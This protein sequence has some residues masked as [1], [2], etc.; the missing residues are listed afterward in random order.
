MDI[1][2]LLASVFKRIVSAVSMPFSMMLI[3][4]RKL[5]NVNVISAKL[6]TPLTKMVKSLVKLRPTDR[7]DYVQILWFW[8]YK[9]LLYLLVLAAC[10]A[11]FIYFG[12]FASAP[13]AAPVTLTGI[14]TDVT[15]SYNDLE[16]KDFSGVANITAYDGQVVYVGEI[17]RGVCSGA[18]ILYAR[19]GTLLYEGLF[20]NNRYSGEGTRYYPDGK[21]EYV[22]SFSDNRYNGEGKLYSSDGTLLYEGG[23][24]DGEYAGAG[25]AYGAGGRLVYEGR[26]LRGRYHGEGTSYFANGAVEYAGEFYEGLFQ[27]NGTLYNEAGRLLYSGPMHEGRLNELAWVGATLAEVEA[28]FPETP[29]IYYQ[30]DGSSCFYYREVGLAFTADCGVRVYEWERPKENISDGYYYLPGEEATS[31]QPSLGA[32]PALGI[33]AL[34]AAAPKAEEGWVVIDPYDPNTSSG[35]SS[36]QSSDQSSSQNSSQSFQPSVSSDPE[37]YVPGGGSSSAGSSSE[38]AASSPYPDFVEKAK[39]LYFE[40]DKDVWQPESEADKSKIAIRKVVVIGSRLPPETIT[41]EFEDNSPVAVDDCAAIEAVRQNVPT[42]FSDV[43]YEMD[44]QNRLFVRVYGISYA[45]RILR[46]SFVENGVTYRYCYYPDDPDTPAYHSIE[47]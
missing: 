47:K 11:V 27:G 38:S 2:K 31:M 26:F 19:D 37:T 29:V 14:R 39:E 46:R 21:P 15:Y 34:G 9:K 35:E 25:K 24:Q 33:V 28:A 45:N 1:F 16:L 8:V 12:A 41:G 40:I 13:E 23:F 30:E 42:A 6:V 3:R 22:G 20:E 5:F 32:F 7:S 44:R 36:S 43:M 18:G 4:F 17:D 10:A